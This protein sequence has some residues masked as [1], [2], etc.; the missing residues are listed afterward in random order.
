MLS[1]AP[2]GRDIYSTKSFVPQD[3]GR[4]VL[5]RM[6]APPESDESANLAADDSSGEEGN[7]TKT[8]PGSFPGRPALESGEGS[9]Y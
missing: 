8:H 3:L 9:Y 4:E 7:E 1:Q 5:A 6:R 2:S